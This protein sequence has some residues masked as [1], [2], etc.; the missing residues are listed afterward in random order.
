MDEVHY[1]GLALAQAR[2]AQS[3]GEVPVGAVLIDEQGQVI[4]QGANHVIG[5]SDPT[6][7]AEI[8]ALRE[9]GRRLKN[10]RLPQT[11]LYVTL[12][13]CAMCLMAL[14]HA[15][16]ARIVY[17]AADP[18]T[19]ACGSRVD[20]TTPGVLNHHA[21]V[22]GGILAQPCGQVLSDFFKARRAGDLLTG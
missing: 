13:P 7:H 12:E 2:L 20:L 10:Y 8:L 9:A 19:G 3:R 1:M 4:G 18:K 17:G 16:V 14:F 5:S 22:Q 11:T 15:R 21:T 6:A